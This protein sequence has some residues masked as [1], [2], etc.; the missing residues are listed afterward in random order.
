MQVL[1]MLRREEGATV[2]Q[3]AEDMDWQPHTVRGFFA[4]I[5][6]RLG[7]SISGERVPAIDSVAKPPTVYRIVSLD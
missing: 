3:I 6:K 1:A 5:K 7:I 4:G 2:G